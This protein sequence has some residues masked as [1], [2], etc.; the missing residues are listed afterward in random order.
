MAVARQVG[1]PREAV[2]GDQALERRRPVEESE[3]ANG[4][5][6]AVG[7]GGPPGRA[8]VGSGLGEEVVDVGGD[9]GHLVGLEDAAEVQ[10]PGLGQEVGHLVAV[11]VDTEGPV[12]VEQA[13]FEVD[14][15]DVAGLVDLAPV[16]QRS[17][18]GLPADPTV[19]IAACD[20]DAR[21]HRQA[22]GRLDVLH[23]VRQGVG[24]E[25]GDDAGAVGAPLDGDGAAGRDQGP[26]FVTAMVVGELEAQCRQAG[27]GEPPSGQIAVHGDG[28]GHHIV[29]DVAPAQLVL[30]DLA[31]GADVDRHGVTPCR[32]PGPHTV[33]NAL[34]WPAIG[35][36]GAWRCQQR[37][38]RRARAWFGRWR[39][40]RTAAC[41]HVGEGEGQD[42][43]VGFAELGGDATEAGLDVA[44][45]ADVHDALGVGVD[46]RTVR[47]VGG[48]EV[49]ATGERPVGVRAAQ[50]IVEQ[51][52]R[53]AQ[54]EVAQGR[55]SCGVGIADEVVGP[56]AGFGQRGSCG[57]G[58]PGDLRPAVGLEPTDGAQDRA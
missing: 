58:P 54:R 29:E 9:G 7:V 45:G 12:E 35:A 1:D 22:H 32:A 40:L 50:P 21:R 53:Q 27:V 24:G 55:V 31:S 52:A 43:A 34:W 25:A 16:E 48:H 10:E 42:G 2:V 36:S 47:R 39:L 56:E 11:V 6:G 3:D 17:Q 20:L 5:V 46:R 33:W 23:Q 28:P 14:E 41:R 30:V 57:L 13:P 44:A 18:D 19:E 26:C 8:V 38:H 37:R 4:K 49:F 15:G 51:R